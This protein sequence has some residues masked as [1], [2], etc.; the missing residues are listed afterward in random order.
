VTP[1]PGAIP[2]RLAP[3]PGE[4]LDSYLHAYAHRLHAGVGDILELAGLAARWDAGR[5]ARGHR[6]WAY[7][8]DPAE[9][10]ALA[11]V[12]GVP[13]EALAEMTLARYDGT[14]LAV[15]DTGTRSPRHPRW[16]R[17]LAGPRFCPRC[18]AG[19][20]GRW[21]LAWWLPWA[22]A[23]TRHHVLLADACPA[24]GRR[25]RPAPS[26]P[27]R[28]P[29][30]C[31]TTGLPLP[32]P[33]PRNAPSCS[34]PPA[35]TPTAPLDPAGP[36]AAAQRHVDT[37]TAALVQVRRGAPD[38]LPAIRRRLDDLH[39]AARAALSALGTPA[40][41]PEAV[42]AALA[43]LGIPG[44]PD[45]TGW[46]RARGTA[47]GTAVAHLMLGERPGDPDPAITGWLLDAAARRTRASPE[48][49]LQR[50]TNA[51]PELE[52]ALLAG[53]APRMNVAHRLRYST[54]APLRTARAQAARLAPPPCPACS[55]EDGRCA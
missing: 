18:L 4:D 42:D 48:L 28:S 21:M 44:A 7:H 20:G 27:P 55:G 50:W 10:G 31:D 1:S 11:A 9:R 51:S 46:R 29:G 12:T 30:C 26:R 15:V 49:L 38:G 53:L 34:F 22:F 2:V 37:L 23:C 14:G 39:A 36:V 32:P 19:N 33:R 43:D 25:H 13:A 35:E 16:W 40:T 52:G 5:L 17:H 3:L 24:C 54:A 41:P 47:L 6:P 45:R 8:L